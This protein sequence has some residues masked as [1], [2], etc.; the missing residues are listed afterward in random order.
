MDGSKNSKDYRF[1]S[2]EQHCKLYRHGNTLN[3]TVMIQGPHDRCL[4]QGEI[5]MLQGDDVEIFKDHLEI[6]Q[7]MLE[8]LKK[9]GAIA[10]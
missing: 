3:E 4:D 2:V 6:Q 10:V 9:Y 1:K 5:N 8:T 7:Q